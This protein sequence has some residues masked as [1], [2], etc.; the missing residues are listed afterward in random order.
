FQPVHNA[1]FHLVDLRP[2]GGPAGGGTT[3]NPVPGITHD[4]HAH[5]Y[6]TNTDA[7]VDHRLAFAAPIPAIDVRRPGLKFQGRRHAIHHLQSVVVRVQTMRVEV[8][9]ARRDDESPR[10]NG[11]APAQG[12]ASDCCNRS[13][14]DPDVAHRVEP[15]FRVDHPPVPDYDVVR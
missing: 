5:R 2:R 10:V 12:G 3:G 4:Q 7:V 8:D 14:A 1:P 11:G 15:C 13:P 9:E 6:V